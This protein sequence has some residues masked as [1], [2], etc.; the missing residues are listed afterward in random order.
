MIQRNGR[1]FRK[2][3]KIVKTAQV[4]LVFE[5]ASRPD[6]N[7][8][9]EWQI[10]C[11]V[12]FGMWSFSPFVEELGSMR[13]IWEAVY[14]RLVHGFGATAVDV[15]LGFLSWRN[16]FVACRSKLTTG[17]FWQGAVTYT[18]HFSSV[19]FSTTLRVQGKMSLFLCSSADRDPPSQVEG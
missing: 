4:A 18:I 11:D 17:W 9:E 1:S 8:M 13:V 19:C 14:S 12:M 10:T 7:G 16:W 3:L 2:A 5:S 6:S 15:S